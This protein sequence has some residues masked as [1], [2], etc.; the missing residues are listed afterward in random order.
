M[1]SCSLV[2]SDPPLPAHVTKLCHTHLPLSL[3]RKAAHPAA[4]NWLHRRPNSV[5]PQSMLT[6]LNLASCLLPWAVDHARAPCSYI[7][8][9]HRSDIARL[10]WHSERCL[11]CHLERRRASSAACHTASSYETVELLAVSS[12]SAHL[13][14]CAMSEN[15]RRGVQL[16]GRRNVGSEFLVGVAVDLLEDVFVHNPPAADEVGESNLVI[17]V[18]R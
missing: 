1:R 12:N 5:L 4:T 10:R 13:C 14:S 8:L 17:G 7:G 18:S 2:E 15:D 11:F 3:Y 16:L 6:P 9:L